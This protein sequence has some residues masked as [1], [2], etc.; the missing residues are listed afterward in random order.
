[1]MEEYVQQAPQ[2]TT[3]AGVSDPALVVR[4]R[5]LQLQSALP[6][7]PS[8]RCSARS[9]EILGLGPEWYVAIGE[10]RVRRCERMLDS[11]GSC[12][13]RARQAAEHM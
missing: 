1:M 11:R 3:T 13:L 4:W 10:L 6:T 7:L 5:F 2:G 12:A 8:A 9:R